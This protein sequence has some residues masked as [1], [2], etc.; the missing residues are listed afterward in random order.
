MHSEC[1]QRTTHTSKTFHFCLRMLNYALT[2]SWELQDKFLVAFARTTIIKSL[3]SIANR[4][5]RC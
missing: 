5:S 1:R 3:T 2:G 4:S